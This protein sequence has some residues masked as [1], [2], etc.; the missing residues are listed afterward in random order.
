MPLRRTD[1]V[2][3][4]KEMDVAATKVYNP[5]VYRGYKHVEDEKV[6]QTSREVI[7]GVSP[8]RAGVAIF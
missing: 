5:T 7:V 4:G 8:L 3:A 1:W 6:C 2:H